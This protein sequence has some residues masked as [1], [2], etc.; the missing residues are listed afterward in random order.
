M[1]DTDTLDLIG[2]QN[3]LVKAVLETG[4]PTVVF[5]INGRPLSAGYV[6]EHVP[7]VFEGWYLGQETGTAVADVVFG[8]YNPSG[9]VPVSVARNVGHLPV[10]YYQNTRA[11][12]RYLFSRHESA[13]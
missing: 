3:D 12:R 4:K 8:D 2:Q 6:F 9:K 11:K 5:L 13:L 1:G 10:Y 7:A